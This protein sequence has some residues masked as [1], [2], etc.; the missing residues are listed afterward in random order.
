M[1]IEIADQFVFPIKKV[2]SLV[3]N[4]PTLEDPEQPCKVAITFTDD[5]P[6]VVFEGGFDKA[7]AFYERHRDM[8]VL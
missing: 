7:R 3:I 6:P 4:Y 8:L 5:T 1:F 2:D